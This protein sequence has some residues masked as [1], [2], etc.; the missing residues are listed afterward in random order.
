[1]LLEWWEYYPAVGFRELLKSKM[2]SIRTGRDR[3]SRCIAEHED[4][5]LAEA[6]PRNLCNVFLQKKLS[7][8]NISDVVGLPEFY[9]GREY[10]GVV[11]LYY[12]NA[13]LRLPDWELYAQGVLEVIAKYSYELDNV[14][15]C[16]V[17]IILKVDQDTNRRS[18]EILNLTKATAFSKI[19][20]PLDDKKWV[21]WA[22]A[23]ENEIKQISLAR[24]IFNGWLNEQFVERFF[25]R[26][27]MAEDRKRYWVGFISAR[28]DKGI[29]VKMFLNDVELRDFR[30]TPELS[31]FIGSRLNRMSTTGLN[32]IVIKYKKHLFVE[33]NLTGNAL[34]VYRLDSPLA[35]DTNSKSLDVNDLKKTS[36]NLLVTVSGDKLLLRPEGR[37]RHIQNVWT[38][39]L[40]Q[41]MNWIEEKSN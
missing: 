40:N 2:D 22:K 5:F 16:L 23:D 14:K 3:V 7:L 21:P 30:R 20:D 36:M 8:V 34:Y 19:G 33:F 26:I 9:Y 35:P 12:T 1:M 18:P 32:A 4:W 17:Q 25:E 31:Q 13:V 11:T 15:K 6:G 29:E 39:Y 27:I 38:V 10:F 37:Y 28:R 24:E 41:W